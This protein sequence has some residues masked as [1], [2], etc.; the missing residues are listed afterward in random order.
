MNLGFKHQFRGKLYQRFAASGRGPPRHG[1]DRVG[2]ITGKQ[3][4]RRAGVA[5]R[6]GSNA[7]RGRAEPIG[8]TS[9]A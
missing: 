4:A 3:A 8:I 2:N 7:V 1:D 6:R 5:G 9:M